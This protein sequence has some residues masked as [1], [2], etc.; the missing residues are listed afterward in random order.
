MAVLIGHRRLA[1][2]RS[3][4]LLLAR[5]EWCHLVGNRP[6]RRQLGFEV[7]LA[8]DELYH[9][10]D[11]VLL[12][13]HR[14]RQNGFGAVAGILVKFP[15]DAVGHVLAQVIRIFDVHRQ[16]GL[17]HVAGNR[18]LADF[19]SRFAERQCHGVVLRQPE[20]QMFVRLL[21]LRIFAVRVRLRLFHQIQ[22]ARIGTRDFPRFCQDKVQQLAGIAFGGKRRADL[23]QVADLARGEGQPLI[24]LGAR[25]QQMNVV[26][27]VVHQPFQQLD[28]RARH[29][30]AKHHAISARIFKPVI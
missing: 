21:V 27:R 22:R 19:H 7:A 8:V 30:V 11:F 13:A 17:R 1:G 15:V 9:A 4:N 16:S 23:V 12:V 26:H 25:G 2:E 5:A 10:D 24:H 28:G 3:H 18:F 20:A 14:H 29:H 6:H